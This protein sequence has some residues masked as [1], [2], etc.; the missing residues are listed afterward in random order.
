MSF[1]AK[2]TCPPKQDVKVT[3]RAETVGPV[4]DDTAST[5]STADGPQVPISETR[6]E[7]T[8]LR[9]AVDILN[10]E[11]VRR[12]QLGGVTTLG[13]WKAADTTEVRAAIA[14]L[15]PGGPQ[16][17]HLEDQCVPERYRIRK[18]AHLRTL[19]DTPTDAPRISWEEWEASMLN[20][21]FEQQG[22]TGK[23]SRITGATVRHG[24]QGKTD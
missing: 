21:L 20:R 2:W 8:L 6:F 11:G 19:E 18:P 5:R 22:V 23:P 10:R 13:I 15:Y 4:V 16:V 3:E 9:T 12:F 17:V 7:E 24:A 14:T 1:L